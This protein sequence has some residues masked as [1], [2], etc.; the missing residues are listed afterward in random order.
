LTVIQKAQKAKP[1][2]LGDSY[3]DARDAYR[4]P[5]RLFG[6]LCSFQGPTKRAPAGLRGFSARARKRAPTQRSRPAAGLSKLNSMCAQTTRVSYRL[7]RH[8]RN[9]RRPYETDGR[10]SYLEAP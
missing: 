10:T 7:G 4:Y 8:A 9:A 2:E 6:Q 1:S 5:E 3:P